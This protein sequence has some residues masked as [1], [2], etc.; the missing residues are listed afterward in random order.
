MSM[1]SPPGMDEY[2][3][4]IAERAA[5]QKRKRTIYGVVLVVA[6]GAGGFWWKQQK[7]KAN[8][9]QAILDAAGRFAEKDKTEMGAFWSC[10]F[11]SEIDV[12]MLQS[13]QQIQQKI[14][15]AYF[16][17]QKTFSDHLTTECVPKIERAR[18]AVGALVADMPA[19]LKPSLDKYV[20]ALPRMQTGIEV[21]AEKIKGRGAVKDVDQSIQEVGGAFSPDATAESVAFEKFLVCAIPDLDKKKDIQGVLEYLAATCKDNAVDF[22]TGVREKCGP[23]VTNVDKDGKPAPS[24][25]FKANTKK[26]YE[27]DQR[28]LQ[29][30]DYCAKRSR[31]GKKQ[32]DLED[33]LTAAG[34]YMESRADLVQTARE[35]A[36]K[37]QGQPLPAAAKK[38]A[39]GAAE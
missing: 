22:M 16:T 21:Y 31:K 6:I 27:E 25:T 39:P 18:S 32:L 2:Q 3:R 10:A 30:W 7:D 9:A 8:A 24:K 28:Q 1:G 20:G 33:F 15:G 37:I 38:A 14:E 19:E 17:Q 29:A 23:L 35:A 4:L 13:A 34:D 36:A 11:G 26:L 12:G 5:A